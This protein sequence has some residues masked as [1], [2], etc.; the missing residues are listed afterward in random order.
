MTKLVVMILTV[1]QIP[2][3]KQIGIEKER[4]H[5][6]LDLLVCISFGLLVADVLMLRGLGQGFW[7]KTEQVLVLALVCVAREVS[8]KLSYLSMGTLISYGCYEDW[9]RCILKSWHKAK[10]SEFL[11]H[12]C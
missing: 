3:E 8:P 6:G 10:C 9:R 11:W 2:K 12:Y 4:E 1:Q 7:S 5:L